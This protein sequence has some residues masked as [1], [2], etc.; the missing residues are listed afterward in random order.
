[1]PKKEITFEAGD[2]LFK[3]G[4]ICDFVYVVVDGA[5]EQFYE[6]R[7]KARP[8]KEEGK[9]AVLGKNGALDGVYDSSV[10]AKRKLTVER[11]TRDEY[12][13]ELQKTGELAP[14]ADAPAADDG[15]SADDSFGF[16]FGADMADV[17]APPKRERPKRP[18][19]AR[20]PLGAKKTQEDDFSNGGDFNFDAFGETPA[21]SAPAPR[22]KAKNELVQV[23]RAVP[24]VPAVVRAPE[25]VRV[26]LKRSGLKQWLEEAGNAPVLYGTTFLVAAIDGDADGAVVRDI[27][28][29][30]NALPDVRV[31]LADKPVFETDARRG[32]LQMRAWMKKFDADAGLFARFDA[33]GRV[34]EFRTAR[35]S[36]GEDGQ[37]AGGSRF[38][39]PAQM[40]EPQKE[41]LRVFAL[42][43]LTPT[44]LEHERL[45]SLYLPD[46]LNRI[47]AQASEPQ[48]SLT[49]EEQSADLCCFA[50]ALSLAG[51]Y[52]PSF[53]LAAKAREI[54]Q[55]ALDLMPPHAP[56]YV[57]LNRQLGLMSRIDGEK[58]NDIEA[59]KKSQEL[60]E[61]ALSAVSEKRQAAQ[62][63][64][65]KAK[66]GAVRTRIAE[67]TG[68][69]EDFT[70]AIQAYR[71]SLNAVKPHADLEKWAESMNGL[72]KSIQLFGMYS[73]KT[74]L[75]ERAVKIYEKELSVL[76]RDAMPHAFAA[77]SN[78]LA[79]ALFALFDRKNDTAL[80][81]RAVEVFADAL[82]MYD[83][84][85]NTKKA[86]VAQVN[87]KLA[88]NLLDSTEKELESRKNWLDDL[89]EQTPDAP[90]ASGGLHFEK[91]AEFED[92]PD[93]E[94]E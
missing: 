20:R 70:A 43:A 17:D 44:R 32:V 12:I 40:S 2:V 75:L 54:Y 14:N 68:K 41:M 56:E 25:I 88:Q 51:Y 52:A 35:L 24:H 80:L 58:N 63:G 46:A 28:D 34:L 22:A 49:A 39:L 4:D 5:A 9:G 82:A 85:G 92:L 87:L 48:V 67:S 90:D 64:D 36:D 89:L 15:F 94:E 13:A 50:D 23:G 91:I 65:L 66:I 16:D 38:F 73:T 84:T 77:A 53:E 8:L 62:W 55:K 78:N 93:D 81:K 1:M 10:R 61:N 18:S 60:F 45:L 59:L 72:A 31:K 69:G 27:F 26:D 29:A 6:I 21:A 86:Q 37:S 33:A 47:F 7:G 83:K 76:D 79:S 30:L 11:M 3:K 71:D 57:F 19:S 42:C 74:T